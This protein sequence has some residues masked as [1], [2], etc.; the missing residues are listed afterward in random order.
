MAALGVVYGDI[1]TSPLYAL[2]ECFHS[3][4]RSRV[5][6]AS[7]LGMLSLIFWS[8]ILIVISVKY[9][10]RHAGRQPGRGR[11]H[12]PDGSGR[13]AA[14]SRARGVPRARGSLRS[15]LLY[16]DSMI[17]P[18]I[19]VLSAVEGLE[20]PPRCSSPYVIPITVAILFGLF[21]VQRRGTARSGAL[22]GPVMILWFL[23]LAVLGAS[24]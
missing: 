20:V 17:T 24:H 6:P 19:S 21:C 10:A 14:G 18:A 8:L 11:H 3:L 23:T 5:T 13:P 12:R 9:L 1:G 22:F 15:A 2:R 4:P 16:G 7:V